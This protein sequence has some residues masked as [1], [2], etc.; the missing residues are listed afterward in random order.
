MRE[1]SRLPSTNA[2]THKAANKAPTMN[3]VGV[4]KPSAKP[5]N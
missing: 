1:S 2:S 4:N 3:I 5:A